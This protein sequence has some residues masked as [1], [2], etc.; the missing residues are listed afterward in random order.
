MKKAVLLCAV[1]L[2]VTAC[3][4]SSTNAQS[5]SASADAP[6]IA[7]SYL[8]PTA[9]AEATTASTQ[10]PAKLQ[11]AMPLPSGKDDE[12]LTGRDAGAA[13]SE[14][15]GSIQA[16]LFAMSVTGQIYIGKIRQD[17]SFRA[18]HEYRDDAETLKKS[19]EDT[20]GKIGVIP[21]TGNV[22][23]ADAVYFGKV[24]DAATAIVSKN[25][26]VAV[27]F[28][29]NANTGEDA[30]DDVQNAAGDAKRLRKKF[31]DAVMNGYR[32]FGYKPSEINRET[33]A[34]KKPA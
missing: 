4:D 8:P 15:V 3:N 10:P 34:I 27:D 11:A 7:S 1:A 19:V 30:F 29:V 21:M 23:D 9:N 5:T 2:Y 25:L 32:H 6:R 12:T 18:L 22:S 28:A 16:N 20:A 26:D 24:L 14:Y 13:F 17:V 31:E 33:L